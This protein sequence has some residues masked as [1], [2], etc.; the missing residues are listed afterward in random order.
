M[1]TVKAINPPGDPEGVVCV[2]WDDREYKGEDDKYCMGYRGRYDVQVALRPRTGT[3]A[4]AWSFSSCS[5][6]AGKTS[7]GVMW[8]EAMGVGGNFV[9]RVACSAPAAGGNAAFGFV[10]DFET[11]TLSFF[12]VS[13][14]CR[15][16]DSAA[17]E[18]RM[19]VRCDTLSLM[20]MTDMCEQNRELVA[21]SALLQD[22][23]ELYLYARVRSRVNQATRLEVFPWDERVGSV[24]CVCVS[25][26]HVTLSCQ[27]QAPRLCAESLKRLCESQASCDAAVQR[28]YG[29][30][31]MLRLEETVKQA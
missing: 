7:A 24:A 25:F 8:P 4:L 28:V 5:P 11:R 17:R 10:V 30:N 21:E 15:C 27:A 12:L 9:R 20:R 23:S 16:L 6:K 14:R 19:S 13:C 29:N 31:P 18:P 2:H 1:G 22:V 26:F 3:D